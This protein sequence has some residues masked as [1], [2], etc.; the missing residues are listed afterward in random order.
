MNVRKERTMQPDDF[1]LHLE[2][3]IQAGMPRPIFKP[4]GFAYCVIEFLG[5]QEEC[6]V[7][8]ARPYSGESGSGT[9]TDMGTEVSNNQGEGP[10]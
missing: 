1:C 2:R 3:R 9:E 4:C 6:S 5:E 10:A 8:S 7:C